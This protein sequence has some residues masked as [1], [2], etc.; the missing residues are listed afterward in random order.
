MLVNGVGGIV[1]GMVMNIL[2]YNFGE[3]CDVM[4]VLIENLDFSFED[5]IEYV[6]G[7]D[8]LIGGIM[9][10][11]FGVCKVYFEGCGFVIICVKICVEEICKDCYVIVIDE[12][13]YQ[14]NKVLMIEKI[15]EQVCEKKIEGVLYVQDELDCNGVCVVVELKCDVM[16]EVVLN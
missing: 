14:V 1:V 8:F 11:C 16:V 2:F 7:F 9:L 15:V 10:G 4:L 3:V 5:L 6:S 13:F 12:I